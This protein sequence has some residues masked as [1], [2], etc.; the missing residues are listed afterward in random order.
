M[1]VKQTKRRQNVVDYHRTC[2]PHRRLKGARRGMHHE[3]PVAAVRIA[4]LQRGAL[5]PTPP[6][7]LLHLPS[8]IASAGSA[9]EMRG[10]HTPVDNPHVEF[11]TR[12]L[13]GTRLQGFEEKKVV[14]GSS[15]YGMGWMDTWWFLFGGLLHFGGRD[16]RDWRAPDHSPCLGRIQ[17]AADYLASL[18]C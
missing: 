8:K 18:F 11:E 13:A 17:R 9:E 12:S 3:R 6:V 1:L 14:G 2:Q 16:G 7:L 10:S 5:F 15:R 4:G